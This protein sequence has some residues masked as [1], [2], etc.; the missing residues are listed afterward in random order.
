MK[1]KYFLQGSEKMILVS[2]M[3]NVDGKELCVGVEIKAEEGF[4]G[5][6]KSW[7]WN[8]VFEMSGEEVGKKM[9]KVITEK[10]EIEI[11]STGQPI[12]N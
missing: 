9:M 7:S 2:S 3:R 10:G 4:C 12:L 11:D 1:S 5:Y 8:E 6:I